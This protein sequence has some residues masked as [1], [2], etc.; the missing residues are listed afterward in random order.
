MWD[1][2]KSGRGSG[3][4]ARDGLASLVI[5]RRNG[6]NYR[7]P[8]GSARESLRTR[9]LCTF[10]ALAALSEDHYRPWIFDKPVD[11][12]HNGNDVAFRNARKLDQPLIAKQARSESGAVHQDCSMHLRNSFIAKKHHLHIESRKSFGSHLNICKSCLVVQQVMGPALILSSVH[13]LCQPETPYIQSD[14]R[15]C[16]FIRRIFGEAV[17]RGRARAILWGRMRLPGLCLTQHYRTQSD[18]L[19]GPQCNP[20]SLLFKLCAT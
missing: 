9:A 11:L 20:L 6:R 2:F 19:G 3:Y 7:R 1:C 12:M 5:E 15:S 4:V 10:R 14:L 18:E 13:K 17:Y 16:H 8:H